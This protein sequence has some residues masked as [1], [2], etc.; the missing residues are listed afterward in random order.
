[1]KGGDIAS[2]FAE[3]TKYFGPVGGA[4]FA[5]VAAATAMANVA[6]VAS[7]GPT[8]SSIPGGASVSA[9]SAPA[10]PASEASGPV[11]YLDVHGDTFTRRHLEGLADSL[12]DLISDGGGRNLKVVMNGGH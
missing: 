10:A 9:P 1:M 12:A 5:G 7:V 2:A 11:A 3:G 6:R 8:S 4:L